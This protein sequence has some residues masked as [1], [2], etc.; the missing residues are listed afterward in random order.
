MALGGERRGSS[1]A[2]RQGRTAAWIEGGFGNG[3]WRIIHPRAYPMPARA[4]FQAQWLNVH[5]DFPLLQRIA[6]PITIGRCA[7]PAS[8]STRPRHQ[9]DGSSL[10]RRHA[11]R[12]LDGRGDPSGHPQAAPMVSTSCVYDLR[13]LCCSV[14]V[15]AADPSPTAAFIIN[16]R[17]NTD[18]T[19]GSKR[20]IIANRAGADEL[21]PD[22][23]SALGTALVRRLAGGHQRQSIAST[24][25][26]QRMLRLL[27]RGKRRLAARR[28]R[29]SNAQAP[30]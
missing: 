18:P 22:S 29:S 28:L 13:K 17:P 1:A 5:V 25:G 8:R 27:G 24:S 15:P 16:P 14:T 12:R 30:I 11:R 9:A 23:T 21:Y 3:H 20:P 26:I 4:S 19:A 10:A 2:D 7:I 6:L